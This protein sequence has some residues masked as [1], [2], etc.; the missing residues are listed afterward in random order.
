MSCAQNVK[1][2]EHSYDMVTCPVK[3][4]TPPLFPYA[5]DEMMRKKREKEIDNGR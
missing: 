2:A 4:A 3:P 1:W 5:Y